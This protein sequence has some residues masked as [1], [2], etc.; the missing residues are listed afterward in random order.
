MEHK[1]KIKSSAKKVV[2]D[3]RVHQ[4]SGIGRYVL[5]I[6]SHLVER[7]DVSVIGDK[8]ELQSYEWYKHVSLIQCS[9]RVFSLSEFLWL[10]RYIPVCDAFWSPH[11]NI[12]ILSFG[13]KNRII[14]LHDVY[15]IARP[16]E[17]SF[18]RRVYA[19]FLISLAL[20]QAH[21][22][23]TVSGFSITEINHYFKVPQNLQIVSSAVDLQ[24]FYKVTNKNALNL[25][26]QYFSLEQ[27]FALFVGN[28]KPNKNIRKVIL[29]IKNLDINLVVVGKQSG[30]KSGELDLQAFIDYHGMSKRVKFVGLI[31]DDKLR[32]MYTL[33]SVFVFASLYE[34]FGIPIL[35]AQRCGCPVVCSDIPCFEEVAGDSAVKVNPYQSE[36][37]AAGIKQ[38]LQNQDFTQELV[39][40]GDANFIRYSWEKSAAKMIQLIE[41]NMVN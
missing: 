37:I 26:R 5:N 34:G 18:I 14:T 38:I 15:I 2:I 13:V 16:D 20:K 24:K 33:A 10:W 31:D 28:I 17:S 41:G 40:K 23:I 25:V 39:Q 11:F 32:V 9:L 29:A 3:L 30:F 7:Y 22:L 19:K 27:N 8:Q 35:E 4:H 1:S 21:T 12:T 36:S 6:I